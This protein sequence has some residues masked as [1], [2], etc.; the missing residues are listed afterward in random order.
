MTTRTAIPPPTILEPRDSASSQP[1]GET[2]FASTYMGEGYTS[3][4]ETYQ[5]PPNKGKKT[6]KYEPESGT[7]GTGGGALPEGPPGPLGRQETHMTMTP[8]IENLMTSGGISEIHQYHQG[9]EPGR[10]QQE[11]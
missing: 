11:H 1:E 3:G 7:G 10:P 4:Y 2:T 5:H 8:V 6:E 9:P